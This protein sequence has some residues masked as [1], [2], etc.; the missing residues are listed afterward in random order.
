MSGLCLAAA[1]SPESEAR[2]ERLLSVKEVAARLGVSSASVYKACATGDL[3]CVRF[4][5]VIRVRLADLETFLAEQGASG[6][7]SKP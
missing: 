6:S 1:A 7:N 5:S 3:R 2:Q 4:L